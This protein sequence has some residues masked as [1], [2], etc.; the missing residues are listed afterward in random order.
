MTFPKAADE[1][2]LEF[3]G[4]MAPDPVAGSSGQLAVSAFAQSASSRDEILHRVVT[5]TVPIWGI[6]QIQD[7]E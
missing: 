2:F 5:V 7:V 1:Q 6:A 4:K 3:E